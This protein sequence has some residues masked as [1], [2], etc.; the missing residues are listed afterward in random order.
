GRFGILKVL[1][2]TNQPVRYH[3]KV[4][5]RAEYRLAQDQRIKDSASLGTKFGTLKALTVSLT[6]FGPAGQTKTSEIKYKVNLDHAKSIFSFNCP[7]NECIGGDFDIS[8]ELAKAVAARRKIAIGEMCCQGWR[9]KEMV[10]TTR[11]HNILRFK[12]SLAYGKRS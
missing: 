6:F 2:L 10:D 11:C 3:H 7:N 8:S 4:G 9:S 5:A 1:K 12:L